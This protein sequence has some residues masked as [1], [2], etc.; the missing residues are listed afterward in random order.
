ML[1]VVCGTNLPLSSSLTAYRRITS[2]AIPLTSR[3]FPPPPPNLPGIVEGTNGG[4][5]I[6]RGDSLGETI[7]AEN[8][9][10]GDGDSDCIT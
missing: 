7:D 1:D 10:G 4:G 3:L 8:T 5:P 9:D 2:L 6:G